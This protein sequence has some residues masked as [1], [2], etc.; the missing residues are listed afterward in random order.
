ML[1]NPDC[2]TYNFCVQKCSGSCL[3]SEVLGNNELP[4][5]WDGGAALYPSISIKKLLGSSENILQFSEF[6][7]NE[8]IRIFSMTSKGCVL[9]VFVYGWLGYGDE[10]LFFSLC[11]KL[12]LEQ[13]GLRLC[14]NHSCRWHIGMEN[15][16][17]HPALLVHVNCPHAWR[18]QCSEEKMQSQ[19]PFF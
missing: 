3:K 1:F 5:L 16:Q 11:C 6:M 12:L 17:P 4:W 19:I 2:H 8:S 14:F 10:P 13:C 15:L 7:V 9:P 18:A